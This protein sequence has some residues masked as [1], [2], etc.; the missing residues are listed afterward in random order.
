MEPVLLELNRESFYVE[1]GE[2]PEYKHPQYTT[3]KLLP[4]LAIT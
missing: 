3:L 4:Q 2:F 1:P